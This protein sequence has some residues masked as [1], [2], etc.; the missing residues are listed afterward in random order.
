VLAHPVKFQETLAQE[1]VEFFTKPGQIVLDPMVGTGSSVVAAIRAGRRAVGFD[2]NPEFVQIARSCAEVEGRRL[3]LPADS[4]RLEVAD[5][6]RLA[7]L[8]VPPV[9]YC[10]TSPP[11]WDMLRRKGFETQRG[12]KERGLPTTYSEDESDLGNISDYEAFLGELCRVYEAVHDLLKPGGY[13]T[14]VVKNSTNSCASV[15]GNFPGWAS[16]S[17]WRGGGLWT[18]Q[19]FWNLIHSRGESSFSLLRGSSV[20]GHT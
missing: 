7:D 2:L 12:R 3:G 17:F 1:F 13:L 11:Y 10:I 8:D 5:A 4:W 19:L 18:N 15:S 14:V 20:N 6:R 16:T 9:D